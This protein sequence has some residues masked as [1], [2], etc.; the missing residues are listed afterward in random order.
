MSLRDVAVYTND[1]NTRSFIGIKVSSGQDK[2]INVMK[3]LN[4]LLSTY[5]LPPFYEV[6]IQFKKIEMQEC[7]LVCQWLFIA[8][9]VLYWISINDTS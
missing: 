6:C 1:E 9:K 7:S 4:D 2:M 5:N 8:H 3:D